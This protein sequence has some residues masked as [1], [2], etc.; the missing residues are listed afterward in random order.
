MVVIRTAK[1]FVKRI[2][3]LGLIHI[4]FVHFCVRSR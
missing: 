4:L 3:D 2:V 1:D